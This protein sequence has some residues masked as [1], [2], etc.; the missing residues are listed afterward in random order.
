MANQAHTVMCLS[1]F[2]SSYLILYIY[3]SEYL[4]IPLSIR[5]IYLPVSMDL[6]IV[7]SICV[8][9]LSTYGSLVSLIPSFPACN[10]SMQSNLRSHLPNSIYPRIELGIC[11]CACFA[12]FLSLRSTLIYQ[13]SSLPKGFS[14]FFL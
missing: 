11:L 14:L 12:I 4:P 9:Y 10:V 7:R 8:I 3:L 13:S 5:Q 1:H 2:P 6:C